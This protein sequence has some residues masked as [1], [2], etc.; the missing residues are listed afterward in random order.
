MV[1]IDLIHHTQEINM[2]ITKK[3]LRNIIRRTLIETASIEN[4]NL[5]DMMSSFESIGAMITGEPEDLEQIFMLANEDVDALNQVF[6]KYLTHTMQ[7]LVDQVIQE[8]PKVKVTLSGI[9]ADSWINLYKGRTTEKFVLGQL[10]TTTTGDRLVVNGKVTAY[11]KTLKRTSVIK[12]AISRTQNPSENY[13]WHLTYEYYN[14]KGRGS[15]TRV[16]ELNLYSPEEAIAKAVE[17]LKG[18]LR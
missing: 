18:K 15:G 11:L 7:Q 2:K 1:G 12:I 5:G 10:K 8:N 13:N 14:N 16:N 4:E 9:D 3:Q 17:K 6:E